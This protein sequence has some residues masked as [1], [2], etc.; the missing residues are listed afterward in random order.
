VPAAARHKAGLEK[1]VIPVS[2]SLG[3]LLRKSPSFSAPQLVL[4]KD[5]TALEI[6]NERFI[7]KSNVHVFK[8]PEGSCQYFSA[9]A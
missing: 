4:F 2:S 9:C 5:C 8:N 1:K 6:T 3:E 7:Y